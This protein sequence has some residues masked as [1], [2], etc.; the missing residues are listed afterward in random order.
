EAAYDPSSMAH[1]PRASNGRWAIA[2]GTADVKAIQEKDATLWLSV[3]AAT[4][5]ALFV[6]EP[7]WPGWTISIDGRSVTPEVLRESG[8]MKIP[9][10]AGTPPVVAAVRRTPVRLVSEIVSLLSVVG[11][12]ALAFFRSKPFFRL[13]RKPQATRERI[14]NM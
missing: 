1:E 8:Y 11:I 7:F 3:D 9:L 6:N 14:K 13:N 10:R 5:V 4:P 12:A 2:D